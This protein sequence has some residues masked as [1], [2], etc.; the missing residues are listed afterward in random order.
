[1]SLG[2]AHWHLSKRVD[3]LPGSK[4][5]VRIGNLFSSVQTRSRID[6]TPA[7]MLQKA[8]DI[9]KRIRLSRTLVVI[10]AVLAMFMDSILDTVVEPIMPDYFYRLQHPNYTGPIII[11]HH[12]NK[13]PVTSKLSGSN[14]SSCNQGTT[15][16]P[17]VNTKPNQLEVSQAEQRAAQLKKQSVILGILYASKSAASIIANPVAGFLS[18]RVGYSLVLYIGIVLVFGATVAY[19]FSTSYAALFASRVVQGLGGSF[20]IIPALVMLAETF[21][22]N[23]ERAEVIGLARSGVIVGSLVGPVIGGVMYQFLGY[24]S[25]FMLIAGLTVVDGVLRL[26]LPK[27][28]APAFVKEEEDYSIVN[29]LKDPYIMTTTVF[30]FVPITTALTV[31]GVV[32]VWMMMTMKASPWQQGMALVPSAVGYVIG[33]VLSSMLVE[34][35]GCW[36]LTLVGT[37]GLGVFTSLL[38]LCKNIPELVTPYLAFGLAGGLL[39][40][41]VL[42]EIGHLADIR[43]GSR[44]GSAFAI[45][46]TANSFACVVGLGI[47][48]A[49]LNAVGFFW[50]ML[51]M[52]IINILLSPFAII[53]RNPPSTEKKDK[54]VI[55]FKEENQPNSKTMSYRPQPGEDF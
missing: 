52:G 2:Y 36:L 33:S 40:T 9:C 8:W 13:K 29:Y 38:P 6:S 54:L 19:A 4:K 7:V 34:K 10:V 3:V 11:S 21:P 1:M 23:T 32:P 12:M 27:R 41:S 42:T 17:A 30:I 49:L 18:D 46:E 24:K 50:M 47:G 28:T 35:A 55:V 14:L 25:P 48:G 43:H 15:C 45:S 5:Y 31:W 44:Y 51:G 26:L 53:L 39:E 22:D 20:S 37:L 16:L